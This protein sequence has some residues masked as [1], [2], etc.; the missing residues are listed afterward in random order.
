M[1]VQADDIDDNFTPSTEQ[2]LAALLSKMRV[3]GQMALESQN[4]VTIT[5]TDLA[6]IAKYRY[7]TDFQVGDLIAVDGN[8]GQ[9]AYMRVT[10][11]VEIQDETGE[12]GHPTL[13]LP[14]V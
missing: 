5:R 14:G 12:S 10:E 13:E 9:I 2:A 4:R 6:G 11:Y 3:R 1:V 8:F 7:R